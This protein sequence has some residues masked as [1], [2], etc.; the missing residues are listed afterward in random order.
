MDAQETLRE[1]TSYAVRGTLLAKPRKSAGRAPPAGFFPSAVPS[2]PTLSFCE[3]LAP[4]L[5]K[6][7]MTRAT[8][9][10]TTSLKTQDSCSMVPVSASASPCSLPV[11]RSPLCHPHTQVRLCNISRPWATK[12]RLSLFQL[13]NVSTVS[14]IHLP[15]VLLLP[16]ILSRHGPAGTADKLG[17]LTPVTRLAPVGQ[18][19]PKHN[20]S[21]Q[22]R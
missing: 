12:G 21:R 5:R 13:G 10:L 14:L 9:F 22:R 8:V 6:R 19:V 4:N 11:F 16:I 1:G 2:A 18:E 17:Q 20:G 7:T 15:S 3:V